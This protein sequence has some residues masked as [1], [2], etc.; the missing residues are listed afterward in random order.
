MTTPERLSARGV[1]DAA[2]IAEIETYRNEVR[3]LRAY[4]YYVMMDLFGKAPMVTENDPINFRG[5]EADRAELFTFVES[6]LN[7]VMPALKD[8]GSNDYG[9]LDK[10]FAQMV[11]AKIYL[12]A[13][14]YIGANRYSDCLSQCNAII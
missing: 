5:P 13:E 9:R 12:N 14:V 3:T 7:A 6:E 1:T 4:S 8:A 11:L 10:A 2:M